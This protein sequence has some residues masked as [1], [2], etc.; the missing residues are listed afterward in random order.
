MR[1]IWSGAIAFGLVNV[2]VKAYSA[3]EDHDVPLHQVHNADGGR[4]RYQRRCEVCGE[5]VSYADIDKAYTD[6]ETMVVLTEDD[7]AAVAVERSR[8]V[9]VLQFVPSGQIDPVMFERSYYLEPDSKSAKAYVLL[10]ETLQKADSTAVVKFTLRQ[11]TRLGALRVRDNALLLQS[12]LWGDEVREPELPGTVAE[13]RVS[14]A[15]LGMAQ[16]LVEQYSSD[17]TPEAFVDEYQNQLRDLVEEKI[18]NG[19]VTRP[20]AAPAA[21]GEGDAEVIDLMEALK[22]SVEKNRQRKGA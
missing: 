11:K 20:E 8:E 18:R 19:E 5:V 22:R 2:P 7:L 12:M 21:T 10:R 14:D 6:G 16:L 17:F 9:E 15:E 1:A 4:I 13:V 3:T